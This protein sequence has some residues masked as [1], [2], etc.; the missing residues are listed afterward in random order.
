MRVRN[1]QTN[2]S[3]GTGR[4]R[5]KG[6][7]ETVPADGGERASRAQIGGG[8]GRL[9]ATIG[10]AL[11]LSA[12]VHVNESLRYLLATMAERLPRCV[13]V[14][15]SVRG[16]GTTF[17]SR[18]LAA[19]LAHDWQVTVCWI[20]LNWWKRGARAE[21]AMFQHSAAD[22]FEGRCSIRDLPQETSIPGLSMVH[23]GVVP[24]ASRPLLTR[25]DRLETMVKSIRGSFDYVVFDLPPV[26]TT[27][28][29]LNLAR[30]SDGYFLV[31]RHRAT[32][33]AQIRASAVHMEAIRPL[34]VIINDA[35]HRGRRPVRFTP[36]SV[37]LP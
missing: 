12:P 34:G 5:K 18:T 26:L 13:A 23:A 29:S 9:E 17:I 21:A 7:G 32:D 22:Y 6:Q 10:G 33:I 28:D 37:A 27:A 16:E 8:D 35:H 4:H 36:R 3:V 30:L 14:T 1:K 24:V 2:Q 19:L 15:S 31:A 11:V 20:D 25:S